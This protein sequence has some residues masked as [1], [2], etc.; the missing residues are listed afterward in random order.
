MIIIRIL[1]TKLEVKRNLFEK[2]KRRAASI[3]GKPRKG[4]A[5]G[6]NRRKRIAISKANQYAKQVHDLEIAIEK[7][8]V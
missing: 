2:N 7:L 1:E 4:T 6:G 3:S 8:K 5:L